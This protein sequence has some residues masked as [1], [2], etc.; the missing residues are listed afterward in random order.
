ML[1]VIEAK[2]ILFEN[3]KQLSALNKSVSEVTGCILAEDIRSPVNLPLFDQSAMDG[4]AVSFQ[5]A[6]TGEEN[7]DFKITGEIKAGDKPGVRLRKNTAVFIYTGS[8]VPENTDC[9]VMQENTNAENGY[10]NVSKNDLI[11]GNNIR[12]KGTQIKKGELVLRKGAF[13][14]SATIGF[15]CLMGISKIKVIGKPM[16]SILSTGNELQRSGAKLSPGKIYES[17]SIMLKAAIT[18]NGYETKFINS[19]KDDKKKLSKYVYQMLTSSD[20]LILSG[21]ISVGKYDLVK[22]IL[23]SYGVKELFYKVSQKPGKPLYA[24]KLKEK[25]IFALP[26]NPA[27]ALVCFYEYVLP[28]I[29]KMSGY[30]E[31]DLKKE[32][33]PLKESY[34]LKGSRDLFLKAKISEGKVHILEGQGSDVLKSFAEANALIYLSSDKKVIKKGSPV[35]THLLPNYYS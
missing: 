15:L 27:S 11:K 29:K 1:S 31:Y 7:Y 26:G 35:E 13:L 30:S 9:V 20:V 4:F 21:G 23:E 16:I 17:N 32:Y 25:M 3:V 22:E 8:A 18:E 6:F 33:F 14:N 34:E 24:G 12:Y 2:K 5:K 10:V 28:A 19:V